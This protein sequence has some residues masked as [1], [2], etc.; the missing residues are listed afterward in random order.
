MLF[1]VLA[2]AATIEV[3]PQARSK[4]I[5][6]PSAQNK[7]SVVQTPLIPRGAEKA[8]EDRQWRHF[9]PA[10]TGNL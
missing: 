9:L 4:A 3:E 5:S 1:V 7:Q 6:N 2:V 10:S 8:R